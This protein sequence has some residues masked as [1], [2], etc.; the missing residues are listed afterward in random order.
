MSDK[1]SDKKQKI[2]IKA[3]TA[4]EISSIFPEEDDGDSADQF[5]KSRSVNKNWL[6]VS[7][8]AQALIPAI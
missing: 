5:I 3:K 1:L 6:F 8:G 7:E 4:G 2:I